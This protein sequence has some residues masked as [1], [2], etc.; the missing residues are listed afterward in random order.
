[1]LTD[2]R[3]G[4]C[5]SSRKFAQLMHYLAHLNHAFV[6]ANVA[7]DDFFVLDRG[8]LPES[9]EPLGTGFLCKKGQETP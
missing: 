3:H 5:F 8:A 7:A 2:V 9:L 4:Y 1:M 6:G